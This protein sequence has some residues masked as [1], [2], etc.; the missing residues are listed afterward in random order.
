MKQ[1]SFSLIKVFLP[2]LKP[3]R[4]QYLYTGLLTVLSAAAE[5]TGPLVLMVLIDHIIPSGDRTQLMYFGLG[6]ILLYLFR[7]LLDFLRGKS[8]ITIMESVIRN[9]QAHVYRHVQTLPLSSF[10]D[11]KTGYLTNRVFNDSQELSSLTGGTFISIVINTSIALGTICV[12]FVLNWKLS[13]V[14]LSVV[15]LFV[16]LIRIF[17]IWIRTLSK[18]IQEE[19]STVY[20]EIQENF[21][22]IRVIKSFGLEKK[23]GQYVEDALS[24]NKDLS[25]KLGTLNALN[26]SLVLACTTVAGVGILWYGSTMVMDTT[27]SVGELMA[28]SAYAVNIYGPVRNLMGINVQ[29]QQSLASAERIVELLDEKPHV[30]RNENAPYLEIKG[31]VCYRD[32]FFTYNTDGRNREQVLKGINL[33]VAVGETVALVG[34]SGAG[35]TT[36]LHL[37][38]RFYDP[39]EGQ[40]LIDDHDLRDIHSDAIKDQIGIV[41][42]DDFLFSTSILENIR[43]GS[44]DATDEQVKE[45]AYKANAHVFIDDLPDGYKTVVGERGMGLSGGERQRISIARAFLKNPRILILD[46]AT[47]SVD[48]KTEN[49]IKDSLYDL[50]KGRTTFLIAHRFS[51]VLDAEKI[52]VVE[53]GEIVSIGR[54]EELYNNCNTY[55]ALYDEQISGLQSNQVTRIVQDDMTEII[56]DRGPQ[57]KKI[58][59]ITV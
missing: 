22:G 44:L 16:L 35:K 36:I 8:M 45:A 55:K 4:W 30:A 52:V 54:H 14:A 31:Q 59:T 38:S 15:P 11:R 7:S 57:N 5:L 10:D 56:I 51:T 24:R 34:E 33:D 17:N 49:L 29:I 9:I 27:L 28:F 32:V 39:Q 43:Y 12:V 20:G 1:T 42:Q 26:I 37:L 47:S 21:A 3:Y 23:R 19:K 58:V 40:I 25:I 46:E 6:F 2:F 53:K 50:M 41:A 18:D 13:L 48:S